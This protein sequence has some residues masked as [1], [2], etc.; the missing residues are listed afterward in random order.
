MSQLMPPKKALS[1][2]DKSLK[3]QLKLGMRAVFPSSLIQLLNSKT[4]PAAVCEQVMAVV[5]RLDNATKLKLGGDLALFIGLCLAVDRKTLALRAS[6][7][8]AS[9]GTQ[10]N[11]L[12]KILLAKENVDVLLEQPTLL[13]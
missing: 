7:I 3:L 1:S 13:A 8:C 5:E 6:G 9:V 4:L 2:L 10:I 12:V 11:E